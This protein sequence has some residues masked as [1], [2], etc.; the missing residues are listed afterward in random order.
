MSKEVDSGINMYEFNKVNMG[1]NLPILKTDD[2][3]EGAK[4]VISNYINE[5]MGEFYM[6]LNHD[7]R[8][9]T[10][11]NFFNGI[12]TTVKVKTMTDD[13]I[14]CMENRGYGLL[15]V[16]L[17]EAGAAVEI[18]VKDKETEAVFMYLLFPYDIGVIKY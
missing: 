1:K 18:W 5:T 7:N 2:E 15:D 11:F 17:D 6:M 12:L 4:L 3:I 14:E 16:N 9:F 8:D 10:L 13:I